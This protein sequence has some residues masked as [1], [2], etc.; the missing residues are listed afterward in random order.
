MDAILTEE[1]SEKFV[2]FYNSYCIDLINDMFVSYPS[3]RS[4]MIDVKNLEKFDIE[5][6]NELIEEQDKILPA[7]NS[8]LLKL[9]PGITISEP[10]YARFFGVETNMPL[11][12][13]VG[14]DNIGRLLTLDAL[15]VKRSEITPKVSTG[16]FKCTFCETELTVRIDRENIPEICPQCHRR[17]LRQINNESKFV[18]M[19]RVA[20]QDPLERLKGST[21]TWHLEVW[22]ED[23]LVNMI[24]P[25]DRVDLTGVLRIKPRKN[26]KGKEDKLLFTMF[27]DTLAIN[28]KQKEFAELE[29]TPDEEREIKEMAKDPQ[30]FEKISRS[31]A[32]SIYG[33][34]EIKKALALQLFGGA[35]DKKLID[36]GAIRSDIHIL[37]I[38][39]PGSAKTRLLQAVTAIVPKGIY[40]SGKSTSSAGLTA[41]AERDEFSEGGWT[42][43][44]GALV[45]GNGG[46]VSIDEFDKISKDDQGGL[47]EALESQSISVAKAGIVAKFS[48][49]T[50]VLA[51]ANPKFGR[52]DQNTYPVEQFDIPPTLMSRFDL[53]FPIKDVTDEETDKKIARHILIQY[54]AAGAQIAGMKEYEQVERP[55]VENEILRKYIAYAR[56]NVHPRLTPDA[57]KRIQDYYIELRKIG[58]SRGAT[59][60]TARQIEAIARLAEASTKSRL[61]DTIEVRDAELAINLLNFMLNTLA[62]DRGGRTDIDILMTGMPR[63]KVNKMNIML[64]IIK[65]FEQAEGYAKI[66]SVLEEAEKQNIEGETARKYLEELIRS[67]DLYSPKAG[68]VKIARA[69]EE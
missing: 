54:E 23:D 15:V 29:I 50:A 67:G 39:D 22:L 6:A 47:L 66:A 25:G 28:T 56:K 44:A 42:L 40:V 46:E 32:P 34:E 20:V 52:F 35:P 68:I 48:A 2:E 59:P 62:T 24:I 7:A 53:I 63:E 3:K 30:I 9:N 65:K 45:L 61:S 57:S 26:A 36:G 12:Q 49:K 13:N 18:N 11:I 8:A 64:G 41:T 4:V 10:V 1:L 60:I 58:L 19:Q 16:K 69:D 14:S 37:L 5:L 33:H 38:G 31:I 21:P 43:K 27:F 17:G 51:A 55:P